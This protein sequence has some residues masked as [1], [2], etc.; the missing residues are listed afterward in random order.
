MTAVP[1][2]PACATLPL[3]RIFRHPPAQVGGTAVPP[4]VGETMGVFEMVVA[5]VFIGTAGKLLRAHLGGKPAVEAGGRV[6]ALEAA[7]RANELRLSQTEDRVAELGEKLVFVE[8][9]LGP[10]A[11]HA[12]LPAS[13]R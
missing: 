2:P 11:E 13:E 10:A 8:N 6:E 4:C 12:R 7:L 9:L 1:P 3:S 5:I